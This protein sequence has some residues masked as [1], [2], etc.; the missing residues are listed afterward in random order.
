MTVAPPGAP[1]KIELTLYRA[2]SAAR[3][4]DLAEAARLLDGLG[5]EPPSVDVLDLRA[6]VHAQRGELSDADRCWARVQELTPDDPAAAA[7]RALIEKIRAGRR[8]PRPVVIT[9]RAATAAV[10]VC[11]VAAGG[12]AWSTTGRPDQHPASTADERQPGPREARR[13]EALAERL[14]EIEEERTAA[15]AHRTRSLDAI[16]EALAMPGVVVH[17]RA[18]EVQVVFESGLFGGDSTVVRQKSGALLRE[19]GRRLAGLSARTTVIGHA[20]AVPGGPTSGGSPFA[21]ERAAAA[22]ALLAEGGRLPLTAFSLATA[23]QAAGPFP[24]A[25]RN[26]TVTLL[27]TPAE[28]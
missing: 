2:R 14:A 26:R 1:A 15:A 27:L 12:I 19:L 25:P 23:D 4:G 13:A 3:T 10:L 9:A 21:L 22:A 8:R 28:P 5:A 24:D 6:R 18:D 16:A 11:T 7:G 17:R 20:V